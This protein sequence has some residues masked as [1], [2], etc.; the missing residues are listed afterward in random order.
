VAPWAG[1]IQR[2]KPLGNRCPHFQ[3]ATKILYSGLQALGPKR[4]K[5]HAV[6]L[7]TDAITSAVLTT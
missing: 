5:I 4:L 7:S 1:S 6:F 3:R 2:P